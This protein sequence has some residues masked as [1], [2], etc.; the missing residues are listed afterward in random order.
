MSGFL[1]L[2][3]ELLGAIRM[4][5]GTLLLLT[6]VFLLLFLGCF[7]SLFL[8]PAGSPLSPGSLAPNELVAYVSPRLAPPSINAL[9]LRLQERVDVQSVGYSLPDEITSER[10]GGHL[11]VIAR[12]AADVAGLAAALRASD[13]ILSVESSSDA[14]G[15]ALT[16]NVRIGLLCGLVVC[17]LLALLLAREGFRSL[18]YGFSHEIR[19]VRLSGVSERRVVAAVEV[20]GLLIGVLAGVLLVLGLALYAL[21]ISESA[22]STLDVTR[23]VAVGAVSL[24]LGALMGGLLGLLGAAHLA[25]DRFAPIP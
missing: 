13:G 19:L 4:R 25:S 16:Q 23:V 11:H 6:L 8:L 15:I 22:G 18:L 12:S 9:S 20:T 24:L 5:S 1:F 21:S 3:R 2:E 14:G 17:A 7:A 10:T